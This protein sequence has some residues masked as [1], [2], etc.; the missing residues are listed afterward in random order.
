MCQAQVVGIPDEVAGEVPLAVIQPLAP[1]PVPCEKMQEFVLQT[2]GPAC[3]PTMFITLQ[4]IG[5]KAFPMT[6]SG[7]VRKDE[8][9]GILLGYLSARSSLNGTVNLSESD[10]RGDLTFTEQLLTKTLSGLFGRSSETIPLDVG[11]FD[12]IDS[13]NTLR[14]QSSIRNLTSKN[15][16]TEEL[17]CA[18]SIR[19]LAKQIDNTPSSDTQAP[20]PST[21]QGTPGV[22]DMVHTQGNQASAQRT[23]SLLQPLLARLDMSW[24]DVED[25]CPV[26][27]LSSRIFSI[28]RP[29]GFS[30]RMTYIAQSADISKLRK[31]LEDTLS[32]WPILRSIAVEFDSVP[33]LVLLRAGKAWSQATITEVPT[34]ETPHEL[35]AVKLPNAKTLSVHA[36]NCGP[37]ARFVISEIKSTGKACLVALIHHATYD[38]ISLQAFSEDLES[39]LK[40]IDSPVESRTTYKLFADTYYQYKNSIPAQM[41]I[42]FHVDRLRGISSL[43]ESCWPPQ[44]SPGWF[45]GD[46]CGH[47]IPS[48]TGAPL[49]QDR[50]QIDNDNGFAGLKGIK[51]LVKLPSLPDLRSKYQISPPMVFKA[52]CAIVNAH[53]SG[54]SEVIFSNTQAG[55]RWPHL[56]DGVA[57]FLPN[58][59]TIAGNT[60]GIVINRI[61]VHPNETG[62][63][64]LRH[65]EDEQKLLT[66]YE[67]APITA[68]A[69]QLNPGDAAA[70]QA[71][72]KQL[73][74]WN[75][76]SA[77]FEV[78]DMNR[79]L[80]PIL[81]EGFTEVMLEWHCGMVDGE[82][83]RV[84][85]RWDGCQAG[86][87]TVEGWAERF[88]KALEWVA[89][90]EN[91]ERMIGEL[92]L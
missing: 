4:E 83:G 17:L 28:M 40:R 7:K 81:I 86:R 91:L 39:K 61:H 45:I 89:R 43:R 50:A 64:L 18:T 57:K 63:T 25:V 33:L 80:Q 42:A 20:K 70:L 15:I 92:E 72:R 55:R 1:G 3:V 11:I 34:V 48:G 9:K 87:E 10:S 56:D 62:G 66:R 13:I 68:I 35:T 76:N 12:M 52:A 82:T 8:L 85:V 47:T 31:V 26:P 54:S 46:D 14:L 78:V 16:S 36:R 88:A 29:L 79:E 2:L 77:D 84:V 27:D 60:L 59:V 5:L 65:L 51:K 75:P 30:M 71:S 6:T 58:P 69:A 22:L 90:V 21:R 49:L 73:F 44:R 32:Q 67:H 23:I 53:L 24:D 41:A 74:N 37:L 38:S 19:E